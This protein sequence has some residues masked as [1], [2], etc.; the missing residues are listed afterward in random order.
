M[1]QL[2]VVVPVESAVAAPSR[3][4]QMLIFVGDRAARNGGNFRLD[5]ATDIYR[6]AISRWRPFPTFAATGGFDGLRIKP[7]PVGFSSTFASG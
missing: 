3:T 2:S 6:E 4:L 5:P 7:D 1:E